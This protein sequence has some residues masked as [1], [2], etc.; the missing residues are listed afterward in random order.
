MTPYQ[1]MSQRPQPAERSIL[2]SPCTNPFS[3]VYAAARQRQ[4]FSLAV[5]LVAALSEF[6]PLLLSNVP[7][8]LTQTGAAATACATLAAVVLGLMQITAVASFAVRWPPMPVDPRSIAGSMYYVAH[9]ESSHGIMM[10]LDDHLVEGGVSTLDGKERGRRVRELGRRYYYGLLAGGSWRRRGVD[11]DLAGRGGG[12][13]A[14]GDIMVATAYTGASGGGSLV[15]DGPLVDDME[16]T[17]L[18]GGRRVYRGV[19]IMGSASTRVGAGR[20]D[21]QPLVGG[22]SG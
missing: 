7:F 3:G 18:R 19:S 5:S 9:W 13:T 15:D 1:M 11:C 6:L 4:P 16:A 20:A 21:Q 2:V 22:E 17:P 10:L 12:G 8:G 14:G